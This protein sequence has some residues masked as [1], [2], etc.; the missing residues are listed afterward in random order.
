[1]D[2]EIGVDEVGRGCLAGDVY[3]CAVL[4]PVGSTPVVGIT[5]SKKLS[6]AKR[7]K[8]KAALLKHPDVHWQV[9]SRTADHIDQY[10]IV[11]S[12]RECFLECIEGLLALGLPVTVIRV[13]GVQIWSPTYFD[14]V[15]TEF[16]PKGDALV[17]AIG[18]ASIIAKVTR[19][20]KM[21]EE[22]RTS[23]LYGFEHHKGYGTPEHIEALR[24]HGLSPLHRKTFCSGLLASTPET[25]AEDFLKDLF[26]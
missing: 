26:G 21:V 8:L 5:D 24:R 23:P 17:W 9:A 15:L 3:A 6:A 22:A 1:M 2:Y 18:A 4:A 13:D 16:L 19:D 10:G 14:P 7:T 25:G 20:E 12:V 11:R